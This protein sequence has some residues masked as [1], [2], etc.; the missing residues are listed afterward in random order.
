MASKDYINPETSTVWVDSGGDKA[1]TLASLASDSVAMGA[2]L[3]LGAAPRADKYA[4]EVNIN[5]FATSTV[6]GEEVRVFFTQS[7]N[8]TGFDGAPTTDP[9]ASTAGTI[10]EEQMYNCL[11]IDTLVQ[12]DTNAGSVLKITSIVTL[13]SRY[14]AP[15]IHNATA[16]AFAAGTTVHTITLTPIPREAQ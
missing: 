12:Y 13:T 9:T 2:Y 8:T 7:L 1:I 6:V 14:V 5:G 15:I 3:D 10:T 11:P 4:L 16:D